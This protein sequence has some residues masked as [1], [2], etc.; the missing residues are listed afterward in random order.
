MME[1][2]KQ[3]ETIASISS[4]FIFVSGKSMINESVIYLQKCAEYSRDINVEY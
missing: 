2:K 1:M 3:Y 4:N